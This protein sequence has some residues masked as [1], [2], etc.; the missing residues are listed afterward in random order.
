MKY[1]KQQT[2]FQELVL[3]IKENPSLRIVP[4]VEAEVVPSDDY[5][6]W[7]GSW[8]KASIDEMYKSDEKI[9]FKSMDMEDLV[10]EI[11]ENLADWSYSYSEEQVEES[12]NA[13][14]WEKVITVDIDTP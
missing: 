3:L 1:Q 6:M 9:Y 2:N 8:G 13:L 10:E 14:M 5:N 12:V 11:A 4:M 7:M